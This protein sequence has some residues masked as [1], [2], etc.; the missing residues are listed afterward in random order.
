MQ[1]LQARSRWCVST[2]IGRGIGCDAT[3]RPAYRQRLAEE[4]ESGQAHTITCR[5]SR[6]IER[7]EFEDEGALWIFDGGEGRSMAICGQEYYGD[8]SFSVIAF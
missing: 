6:I 1:S 7:E 4:L 3:R 8:A 2:V 5:P